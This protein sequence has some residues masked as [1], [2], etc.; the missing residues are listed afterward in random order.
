MSS[1]PEFRILLVDDDESVVRGLRNV[2]RQDRRRWTTR[3]AGGAAA[4]LEEL[5]R[6]PA[7]VVVSD[8]RMPG[9]DGVEFL[10]QV[11]DRWPAT[12]R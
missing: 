7:D 4:A 2:L 5:A 8:L 1:A 10:G 12:A 11:L 9:V 3:I 6:E